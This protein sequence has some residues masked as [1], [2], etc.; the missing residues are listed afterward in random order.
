MI[1]RSTVAEL[2]NGAAEGHRVGIHRLAHLLAAIA[3]VADAETTGDPDPAGIMMHEVVDWAR[4]VAADIT[5]STNTP[6]QHTDTAADPGQP[7]DTTAKTTAKTTI[8]DLLDRID[9]DL[10]QH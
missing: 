6:D 3:D 5:R 2:R 4:K 8:A 1:S 9:A 7:A 10:R